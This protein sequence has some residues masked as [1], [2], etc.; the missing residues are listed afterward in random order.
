MRR[1]AN[2][3]VCVVSCSSPCLSDG[4]SKAFDRLVMAMGTG[5]E[6]CPML[7]Q[8]GLSCTS[9]SAPVSRDPGPWFGGSSVDGKDIGN[10]AENVHCSNSK[11]PPRGGRG[12][13]GL[14]SAFSHAGAA[15]MCHEGGTREG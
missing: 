7:R 14:L 8:R 11:A 1:T 10:R 2:Y 12:T 9:Q 3:I 5:S 6:M 13:W 15:G 4:V